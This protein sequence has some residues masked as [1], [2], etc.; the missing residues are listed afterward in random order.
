MFKI[1]CYTDYH[2]NITLLYTLKEILNR[3]LIL[4]MI[5]IDADIDSNLDVNTY[6]DTDAYTKGCQL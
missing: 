1:L 3:Y 4:M 6:A 2:I 5:Y